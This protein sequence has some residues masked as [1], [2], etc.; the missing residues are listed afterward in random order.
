M[1]ARSFVIHY[2]L[3]IPSPILSLFAIVCHPGVLFTSIPRQYFGFG[4]LFL[5]QRCPWRNG[6]DTIILIDKLKI[7]SGK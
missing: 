1:L 7:V 3:F 2:A 5:R 6:N 4:D